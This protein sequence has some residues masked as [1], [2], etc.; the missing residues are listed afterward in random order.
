MLLQR[1]CGRAKIMPFP[2]VLGNLKKNLKWV[3]SNN[4]YYL[5]HAQID[6]SY[7]HHNNNGSASSSG[8]NTTYSQGIG[9]TFVHYSTWP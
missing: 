8:I 2:L 5:A 6:V 9:D 7:V 1:G 3:W 4:R